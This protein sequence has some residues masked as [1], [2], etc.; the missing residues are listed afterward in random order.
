MHDETILSNFLHK[1]RVCLHFPPSCDYDAVTQAITTVCLKARKSLAVA[2][3]PRP[4]SFRFRLMRRPNVFD[5]FRATTNV[6]LDT[7]KQVITELPIRVHH[8][9][10]CNAM[11]PMRFLGLAAA[12]LEHSDV[13]L[14]EV[15]GMDPVGRTKIHKYAREHYNGE[16]LI[17]V[18]WVPLS[19]NCPNAGECMAG[20]L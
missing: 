20:T 11:T 19:G 1:P 17:H 18:C 5:W 3:L 4:Q 16:C 15:S 2:K 14:Y 8:D 7:A 13:L 10:R 6:S 9:Y 12:I